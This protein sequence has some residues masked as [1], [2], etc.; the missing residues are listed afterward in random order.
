M[1]LSQ[2]PSLSPPT[3][4]QVQLRRQI[5]AGGALRARPQPCP[6]VITEGARCL[7]P[8]Q[9]SSFSL[10]LESIV[11]IEPTEMHVLANTNPVISQ[12]T[13]IALLGD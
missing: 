8:N 11:S 7:G 5:S 6:V 3:S 2:A 10:K 13:T 12:L 4:A 9:P 1:G